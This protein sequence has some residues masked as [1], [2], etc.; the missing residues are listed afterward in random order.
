MENLNMTRT[1]TI[2]AIANNKG[3]V[4]KTTTAANLA[5]GL[6][7]K[8][9]VNGQ[10]TGG[11]LLIDLD[12]QGN[13][14]DFFGV[15]TKVYHSEKNPDGKCVSFLLKGQASLKDSII[16]LDRAEDGLPRPNL[17][18]IPASRELEY[19]TEE[20]LNADYAAARRPGKEHVPINQIL[21][22]RLTG[23]NGVFNYIIIDCPP[24]LDVLKNAVYDFAHAV[25]VPT[26]T[27]YI[28]IVGAVQHTEDL[29]NLRET[30]GLKA[31]LAFVLPTMVSPRQIMDRQM[32]DDLINTY[33][34]AR[35]AR[36][37]PLSVKVKESPGAG[38][39]S[40]F[41][42]APD[43]EPAVAYRDLVRRVMNVRS[44]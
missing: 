21:S 39:Q 6:A 2:L 33:G 26:K 25:I 40:L 42:Y 27:D 4:A 10:P 3:G 14:A 18:L 17:Y 20:L 24:K 13:L 41:E 7:Q 23:A 12:P 36:P 35:I 43:S 28:S 44:T 22:H 34:A 32:Y 19:A 5:H 30:M 37:I 15:R 11:V 9:I 29:Y 38:G 16:P 1:T 31:Q 8:F